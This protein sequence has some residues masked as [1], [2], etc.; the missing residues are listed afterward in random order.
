MFYKFFK[1][2]LHFLRCENEIYA[3]NVNKFVN[4]YMY[5]CAIQP[6]LT[7]FWSITNT[8]SIFRSSLKHIFLVQ[9]E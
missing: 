2:N 7:T 4:I 1:L 3:Y 8:I 6:T 9:P 5:V